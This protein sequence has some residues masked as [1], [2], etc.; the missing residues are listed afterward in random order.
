MYQFLAPGEQSE[1]EPDFLSMGGLDKGE[2]LLKITDEYLPNA[3]V[4]TLWHKDRKSFKK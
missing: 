4:P 2:V 3:G 1:K